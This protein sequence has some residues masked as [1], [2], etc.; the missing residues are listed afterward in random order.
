MNNIRKKVIDAMESM[1]IQYDIIEHPAVYTIDEMDKLNIDSNNEVVKNLFVRDD[2]KKRYFLI[3][4]QKN[5][6]VNLKEIRN[7]LNC[8]PLSFASEEDLKKYMELSKGS[9]TPFGILNDTDCRVDVVFDKNVLLFE[10]IGVHPNDNTATVWICP[11][12]L[13]FIIK[14][15]GNSIRYLNI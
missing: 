5:K 9:V 15:H 11:K 12:D 4:L 14:N 7:E 2:K 3:V 10:R 13:E 6:Q 1:N 8:R